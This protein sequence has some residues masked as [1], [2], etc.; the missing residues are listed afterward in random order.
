MRH[1][2]FLAVLLTVACSQQS[3]DSRDL[4]PS[5]AETNRFTHAMS[6][7]LDEVLDTQ[8]EEIKARYV[9]RNPKETLEFFGITPGMH[10]AEA[11]P[12]GGWYSKILRPYLGNQGK[13]IGVDYSIDI[14][15][16]FSFVNDEF[17]EKRRSW[18]EE[19]KVEAQ[20]WS[21]ETGA[22]VEAYTFSTLP[23]ELSGTVDA[24]LFIR[25]LHNMERYKEKTDFIGEAISE[26][27]RI[28]KPGGVV[29]VVQHKAPEDKSDEWANGSRGYLK[30]STVIRLFENYGFEFVKD[31]P[32]NLNSK[33]QPGDEDIVWRLPPSLST[34]KD[35]ESLRAEM[36]AIGE[37]NR[38][39]LL[40]KKP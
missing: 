36:K 24:V 25:A 7:A 27:F 16:N 9:Y 37:S 13:L 12:G 5:Q 23:K 15:Q 17:I 40:F 29:G 1:L 30:Q 32:I 6:V 10:V 20:T 39:T 8:P 18:T 33:D 4:K 22:E 11:L 26:S 35:N 2:F 14:W 21:G 38:M 3:I 31:S 19:W 34:S 28:L